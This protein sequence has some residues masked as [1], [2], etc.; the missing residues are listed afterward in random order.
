M[1]RNRRVPFCYVVFPYNIM[2]ALNDISFGFQ[3]NRERG[4]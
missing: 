4:I 3:N 1:G 2:S